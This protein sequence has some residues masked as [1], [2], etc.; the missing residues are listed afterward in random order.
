MPHLTRNE[1]K[2][3]WAILWRVLVLGPIV[4]LFG[5]ALLAL[6][7]VAFVGPLAC[8]AIAF[9][10]GDWLLGIAALAVWCVVLRFGRSFLRWTLEGIEHASI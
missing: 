1:W 7:S 8:A 6:V 2:G 10:S 4:G 9:L 5:L 3:L